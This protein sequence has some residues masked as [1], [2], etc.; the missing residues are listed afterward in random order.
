MAFWK[1]S[2]LMAVWKCCADSHWATLTK[3]NFA[4]GLRLWWSREERKP[5]SCRISS[6]AAVH[7][8]RNC[9][10]LPDGTSNGLMSVTDIH[11][12]FLCSFRHASLSSITCHPCSCQEQTFFMVELSK[13]PLSSLYKL[14]VKRSGGDRF[15]MSVSQGLV[16]PLPRPSV[17]T[18][19]PAPLALLLLE[20]R[21]IIPPF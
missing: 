11:W 15:G 14:S 3:R 16:A 13:V 2:L 9:S 12:S 18:Y 1:A 20:H 10:S 5:G 7:S 6:A 21:H 17:Q 19:P 8:L 4:C